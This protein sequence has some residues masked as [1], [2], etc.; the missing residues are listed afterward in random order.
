V[1]NEHALLGIFLYVDEF[2]S[3]LRT[4]KKKGYEVR[5]AFSPVRLEEMQDLLSPR[6]SLTRLFTLVGGIV[7]GISLVALAV[8]AH[9]SFKLIVWGKPVLAW[10]PWVVVA[11]EGTILFAALSSFVSWVFKSGLPQPAPDTGYDERFSGHRFGILVTAMP[12]NKEEIEKILREKGA[13]EVR[14]VSA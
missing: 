7:G 2:L 3:C 14:R 4:L 10:V 5:S 6:P 12:G 9:L 11:F 13:E 8:H 1:K